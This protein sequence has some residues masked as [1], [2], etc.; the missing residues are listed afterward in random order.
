VDCILVDLWPKVGTISR[1]FSA[2]MLHK[3]PCLFSE[4]APT[5]TDNLTAPHNCT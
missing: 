4:K 2:D 3:L 5:E 1:V